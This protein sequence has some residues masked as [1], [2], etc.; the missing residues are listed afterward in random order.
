[1]NHHPIKITPP[2]T[3][4]DVE[5]LKVGDKVL[6]TGV[7]YTA[8]D[9]AHKRLIEL[10]D[11]GEKLPFDV[12]GQLIYYVGPTPAKPGQ[13]IGSAGP[14]TSGR[15]DVY[16]PRLLELGLK[17]TIGKGQRSQEVIDAMKKNKAVYLAAVGGAAALIAK[18]IKR[19]EIIVYEDLGPE[20]I[21]RLEVKD[22]P[23]IV[24]N[25]IYGSDLFKIGV[26]KY[27]K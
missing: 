19:A 5:K 24:V 27:K 3:D 9:A 11:K 10:L 14:T 21:R 17:G 12:K 23:A 26:E 16:T 4:A 6:I 25:D 7:L 15:M 2:L 20:A 8:R 22:F 18:T 13:V 1:M